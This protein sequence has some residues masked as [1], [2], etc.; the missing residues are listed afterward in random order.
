MFGLRTEL[1][2]LIRTGQKHL[3]AEREINKSPTAGKKRHKMYRCSPAA[4][5]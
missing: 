4:S 1:N 2:S 5:V 3:I